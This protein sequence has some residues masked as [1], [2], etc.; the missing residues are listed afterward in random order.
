MDQA[1]RPARSPQRRATC[2]RRGRDA[3]LM[4]WLFYDPHAAAPWKPARPAL[5]V[6]RG[7]VTMKTVSQAFLFNADADGISNYYGGDFEPPFLRA[8]SAVDPKGFTRSTIML[9]DVIVSA[10]CTRV[11]AVSKEV[12]QSS[13]TEG[14]D[15]AL[16]RTIIWDLADALANQWHTLDLE[17]FPS[18]L[19]RKNV[20]CITAA[21]LPVQFREGI[22]ARLCKTNGYL[23]SLEID[24]GNPIQKRL[25]VD[26]LID[27]AVI[28]DGRVTMELSW[29]G[30]PETTFDGADKF[31]PH[32]EHR[33]PDG[34]LDALK[35]PVPEPDAFSARGQVSIDRYNGKR[36]YTVHDR[37]LLALSR[38]RPQSGEPVV[39]SFD[40]QPKGSTSVLEAELPEAKFVQYLL[41]PDHADGQGKAKFFRDELGIGATDWRYLAA[42][43]YAGLQS[44]GL[45][46]LRVKSWEDGYGASFNCVMPIRGLNSRTAMV[47]TNWIVRPGLV[48]QLSTAFPAKRDEQAELG[49]DRLTIV[50]S[51]LTGDARWSALYEAAHTAG[52]VAATQCVPTPMKIVGGELIMEGAFGFAHICVPDARKG[53]A[54][55]IVRSGKGRTRP[56]SGAIIYA[57]VR[58]QSYD[59]AVAYVEAFAAILELNGVG[60]SVEARL[61]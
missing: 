31:A 6:R 45:G 22:N 18:I 4:G 29:E 36:R 26:Q 57:S 49:H 30:L 33:V 8:L 19:A 3:A 43:L 44:A 25:L 39:Y 48:P 37:V 54:R 40:A 9:G 41:N 47:E 16:Y 2:Q 61:D 55:W 59:R 20:Y 13:H 12:K 35:P 5:S 7:P 38:A 23:G 51:T 32:G 1:Q 42:Q 56:R 17:T 58:S 52:V 27:V 34:E 50:P 24:R 10:L 46:K 21:S 15:M 14:Y 60:C 28:A 11:I 53:F